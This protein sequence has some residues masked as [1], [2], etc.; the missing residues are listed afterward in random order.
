MGTNKLKSCILHIGT[1]K[2]GTTTLQWFL[3]NNRE[4]L[5]SRGFFV[6]TP[7]ETGITHTFLTT[8]SLDISNLKDNL[9]A[10]CQ[11]KNTNDVIEHRKRIIE[12]LS[13]EAREAA[14]RE[15]VSTILLS[16]ETCHSRLTTTEEVRRLKS[17]LER[18]VDDFTVVVYLRPQHELLVSIYDTLL[19]VGYSD[20]DIMPRFVSDQSAWIDRGYFDYVNLLK[21]WSSVFGKDKLQIRIFD[22]SELVNGSI[23]NDF[24]EIIGLEFRDFVIPSR[25]NVSMDVSCQVILNFLNRYQ[26]R[27]PDILSEKTR[28]G[29]VFTLERI[30]DGPGLRPSRPDAMR[31][32]SSF[33][34]GNNEISRLFFTN[35]KRLFVPDFSGFPAYSIGQ[36]ARAFLPVAFLRVLS[37]YV[38]YKARHAVPGTASASRVGRPLSPR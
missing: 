29:I 3:E 38:L 32:L 7:L 21:R 5:L 15:N 30:S 4:R 37:N 2:T 34:E 1:E 26:K 23:L 8:Y 12:A 35:R 6:P 19:K 20:I 14:M 9:R 22:K 10:G 24:L 16:N 18:F 11:I 17:L 31:F 27:F 33:E 13:K 36:R 25:Q 28:R